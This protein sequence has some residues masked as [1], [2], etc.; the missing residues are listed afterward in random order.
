M[1]WRQSGHDASPSCVLALGNALKVEE[2]SERESIA[3]H[4]IAQSAHR[5][6]GNVATMCDGRGEL[7]FLSRFLRAGIV[8]TSIYPAAAAAAL[9]QPMYI[10]VHKGPGR[11]RAGEIHPS[12]F[13]PLET[14]H[15]ENSAAMMMVLLASGAHVPSC[16]AAFCVLSRLAELPRG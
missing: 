8:H 10:A 14:S 16:A 4:R 5:G 7:K 12:V 6:G 1:R 2:R 3:S 11:M 13:S 9:A 15:L